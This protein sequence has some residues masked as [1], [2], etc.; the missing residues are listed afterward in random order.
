MHFVCDF[1]VL[2]LASPGF[3]FQGSRANGSGEHMGDDG[4][5]YPWH[6]TSLL[7]GHRRHSA[8]EIAVS[9]RKLG[10]VMPE[11]VVDFLTPLIRVIL[12]DCG[13]YNCN[14]NNIVYNNIEVFYWY[15]YFCFRSSL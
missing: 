5:R 1:T 8:G 10:L 12:L 7:G 3:L 2:W 15:R 4:P 14:S 13:A 9:G 6:W 11:Q